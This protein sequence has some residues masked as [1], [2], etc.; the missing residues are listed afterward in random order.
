[1]RRA[2]LLLAL[3]AP[4]ADARSPRVIRDCKACGELVVVPAGAFQMGGPGGEEGRPEGPVHRVV[5]SRP[6]AVGRTEVTNAQFDRFRTAT[7]YRASERCRVW[8]GEQ[9]TWATG[10]RAG[11]PI[12][13]ER[14]RPTEPVTCVSWRDASAFA[15]W[16]RQ[17][18][19]KPYRLLSEAEWEYAARAGSAATYAWGEDPNAGC[20]TANYYDRSAAARYRFGWSPAACDDGFARLA[21]AGALKANAFGLHDMIGNVWEWVADC[22]VAPYPADATGAAAV[23]ASPCE[24]RVS[25]GGS[26]MT[27]PDRQRYSFRGRDPEDAAFS[28]FGFR[29]GRDLGEGERAS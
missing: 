24:R 11:E 26:W 16:L 7:G 8:D 25:R 20:M 6:F 27:R 14:R 22:Y 28:Y 4:A 3:L 13:G 21:P 15:A 29:V 19:G 1:M 9:W 12:E 10:V 2:A 23:E 5:I 18:T 17:T